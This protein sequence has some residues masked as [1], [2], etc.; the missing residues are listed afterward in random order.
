MKRWAMSKEEAEREFDEL[1]NDK[2]VA[3]STDERGYVCIAK[4]S[5]LRVAGSRE[6]ANTRSLSVSFFTKKTTEEEKA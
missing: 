4:L 2:N 6:V 5:K 3:Q 1:A